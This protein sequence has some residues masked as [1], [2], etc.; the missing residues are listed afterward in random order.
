VYLTV[1]ARNTQ[2]R[3]QFL[4]IHN[5]INNNNNNNNNIWEKPPKQ[6]TSERQ[7]NGNRLSIHWFTKAC[8]G[9]AYAI[10]SRWPLI[11]Y[12][13]SWS[14]TFTRLSLGQTRNYSYN[15]K[16]IGFYFYYTFVLKLL[17]F[18]VG[19][20][21]VFCFES[22]S[23]LCKFFIFQQSAWTVHTVIPYQTS[24][25]HLQTVW[26][27][28]CLMMCRSECNTVTDGLLLTNPQSLMFFLRSLYLR[29]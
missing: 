13:K 6:T 27:S 3:C 15:V 22:H 20:R 28:V 26:C 19:R 8:M 4:L 17:I 25:I 9:D 7:T 21:C 14:N 11:V 24:R 1:E 5:S 23:D 29:A 2:Q 10:C 16:I 12:R 18:V